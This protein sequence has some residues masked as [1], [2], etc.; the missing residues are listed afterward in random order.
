MSFTVEWKSNGTNTFPINTAA[1][2]YTSGVIENNLYNTQ[3]YGYSLAAGYYTYSLTTENDSNYYNPFELRDRYGTLIVTLVSS[4]NPWSAGGPFTGSFRLP[5]QTTVYVRMVD[6]Y[7][8]NTR[9]TL[10][11]TLTAPSYTTFSRM[12]ASG[13]ISFSDLRTYL[14][15][16]DSGSVSMD[17]YSALTSPFYGAGVVGGANIDM[18]SF[19]NYYRA[20]RPG[21]TYRVFTSGYF[22]DD[23]T[24]FSSRTEQYMGSTTDMTNLGTATG[25]L[26]PAQSGAT[27]L[28]VEWF[29]YFFARTAGSYT[30]YLGTDDA[31]Y[32]WLGSNALSGYTTSNANINNGSLHGVVDVSYTVTLSANTFY[33]IRIQFGQNAGGYDAQFSFAGPSIS[34]TYNMSGYC[35]FPTG[36]HASFPAESARIIRNT[37][38]LNNDGVYYI[39]V[40]GT[41][42]A[43]YCLMD[44]KWNG[45]G[46]MMLM[47]ATRGTTF[48]FDSSYWTDAGTTTNTG[49]TNRTDADAKFNVFNYA[50]IKDV[51]ALWP[52]SG[53]TGGC[54][55]N[56][57]AWSWLVNNWYSNGTRCTAITGFSTANTRNS[58][59]DAYP[60]SAYPGFTTSIWTTQPQQRHVFGG[61]GHLTGPPTYAAGTF[62][63]NNYVRWGFLFN[64]NEADNFASSDAAGG[65]GMRIA[66]GSASASYSGGDFVGCCQSTT[67][68]NRS[69][70]FELYG[71]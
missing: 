20:L 48:N 61:G 39:N 50:M 46:W 37:A 41:S 63:V 3:V 18:N 35:F 38:N 9:A 6:Y 70:R 34:R 23:P 7:M 51:M 25:S 59:R 71:R 27:Y 55:P 36:L 52:D 32:M 13:A 64:E 42:T 31:G 30:F 53:Y 4:T 24:W 67:G 5:A 22:A 60:N 65:I 58:P 29:G 62:T 68:L 47:K 40:N 57:D 45:G 69:M 17:Q 8:Y 49:S 28:S 1:T 21:L 26:F 2:T 12:P 16:N 14:G 56:A 66:W 43:T 10:T 19:Y 15:P 33:P 11:L 44:S 54:M